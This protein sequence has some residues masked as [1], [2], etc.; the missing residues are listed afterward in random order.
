MLFRSSTDSK[1]SAWDVWTLRKG[2][3]RDYTH[4]SIALCRAL[5]IPARYLG[6]YAIG[7]E[8]MDFHACF[9]VYLDG[10]WY[11]LDPTDGI[12][13]EKIVIIARGRDAANAP[14]AT[15]FGKV[16][17]GPVKVSCA[18]AELP[19]TTP[20]EPQRETS[21]PDTPATASTAPA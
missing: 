3:C 2:V 10:H 9:E 6:G 16:Q 17:Y 12:A 18:P 4:L 19:E 11:L 20:T 5:N 13:P 15:I 1:T 8:P 7:L 21:S 14:L